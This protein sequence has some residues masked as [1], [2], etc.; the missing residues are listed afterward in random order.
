MAETKTPTG[1]TAGRIKKLVLDG[2]QNLVTGLGTAGDKKKHTR[3]KIDVIL[4]DEELE[5]IYIS[6]GLGTR[7]VNLITSDMFRESWE[8]EFPELDEIDAKKLSEEYSSVMEIIGTDTKVQEGI[9]WARLYGGAVILIGA[10]DGQT[11]DKPLLPKRIRSI[12]SLR[13]IDRSDIVFS[14]IDFQKDSQKPRYGLPE[15]Y[16]IK[17]SIGETS[18]TQ[19]VHYSRIIEIHGTIIPAGATKQLQAEQRYWGVSVLQNVY[20]HLKT[21]GA[22]A[23]NIGAL[24][25]E[26]SVGKYKLKG[27]AEI[28][29]MPDGDKL[30][31]NRVQV[32]DLTRSVY[33]SQYFDSDEDFIRDAINFGGVPEVLY[34]IIMLVAACSGYPITRLFGVSPAGMNATGESDM[35]NYYDMV[36]AAQKKVL[37][38]ILLRLVRIIS[39]WK[40]IEEP[41]IKFK[42]LQQ[43][44]DKEQ[45]E[46][47]KLIADK[48]LVIANTFQAYINAGMMEPYEARFLQFGDSLDEIPVPED[49]L[50]P[51]TPVPPIE[52]PTSADPGDGNPDN[53]LPPAEDEPAPEDLENM[54]ADD[55]PDDKSK[56][57]KAQAK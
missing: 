9:N 8:Y 21:L 22:S 5:S 42:P 51:V 34:I 25:D 23:G 28:L 6:D 20:D 26:M 24:L 53:K 4:P 38:P 30:I 19:R 52:P 16:P 49:M 41:Y 15:Y 57:K 10:L 45:A 32:M 56:K 12:E 47:D 31:Q 44:S 29:S 43:L 18:Q 50:P 11:L 2:W 48:D 35:R 1:S 36:R 17:F 37:E 40:G 7:I 55:K 13:V 54:G 3:H 27:L 33:R 39:E 14:D 46:L